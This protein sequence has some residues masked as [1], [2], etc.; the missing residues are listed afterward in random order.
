[1]SKAAGNAHGKL[2]WPP[3]TLLWPAPALLVSCSAEHEKPNLI[4]VAWGGT[5]NSNPPMLSISVRPERHSHG[6]IS[7]S[8]EFV[9]N[10]PVAS[11]A[12][13]V[14]R[15]GVVSGRDADKF[16]L[17]GLTP[18]PAGRVSCPIV[19]ECPIN[20]ECSVRNIL[21]LGTH[22]LFLAE[23]L[24]VQVSENMVDDK[25]ALRVERGPLLAYAHGFYFGLGKKLGHF[26][27]SVR[28]TGGKKR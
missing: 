26:G 23:V 19:A 16:A 24:A 11:L 28:K 27:F 15:C 22:D 20:I 18:A 7:K 17:T 5:I 2:S 21:K 8:G 1:M 9:A 14:D 4:T 25:G 3:G 13:A 6:M 12:R 10:V